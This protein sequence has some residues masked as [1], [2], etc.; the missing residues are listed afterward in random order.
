M[1]IRVLA[2]PACP[3]LC[4]AFVASRMGTTYSYRAA[5]PTVADLQP[6]VEVRDETFIL[7]LKNT[8]TTPIYL[9]WSSARFVDVGNFERPLRLL[10]EDN[11]GMPDVPLDPTVAGRREARDRRWMSTVGG[12]T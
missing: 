1:T 7:A 11:V 12:Q 3:L 2:G 4:A 8:T 10:S 6:A 5:P 9:D